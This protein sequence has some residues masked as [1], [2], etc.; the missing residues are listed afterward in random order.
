MFATF[1][2]PKYSRICWSFAVVSKKGLCSESRVF[3]MIFLRI[4]GVIL[5]TTNCHGVLQ[6][7]KSEEPTQ[8]ETSLKSSLDK[9]DPTAGDVVS[10]SIIGL[11]ENGC[12]GVQSQF[13]PQEAKTLVD[14]H[15]NHRRDRSIHPSSNM[16]A[17]VSAKSLSGSLQLTS[18]K[19]DFTEVP[20]TECKWVLCAMHSISAKPWQEG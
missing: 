7:S 11:D 5:C 13:T 20:P 12:N 19:H 15:N 8:D 10:N 17:L 3:I 9:K 16:V 2:P 18:L 1:P 14:T 6:L 4:L